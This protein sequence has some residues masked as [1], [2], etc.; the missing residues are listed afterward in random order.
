MLTKVFQLNKE[1][2][3]MV[4]NLIFDQVDDEPMAMLPEL[5]DSEFSNYL[6]SNKVINTNNIA[7]DEL[8]SVIDT[9]E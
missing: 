5:I 4:S 9:K 2:N 1:A 3:L 6:K 7:V 8:E